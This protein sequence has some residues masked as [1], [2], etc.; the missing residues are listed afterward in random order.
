MKRLIPLA[1]IAVTTAACNQPAEPP[2]QAAPVGSIAAAGQTR[3]AQAPAAAL[4][5]RAKVGQP[6]PD[7]TLP[8]LDGK[9]VELSAFKG[10]TVVL[11]WFNAG[12]PFVQLSHKKGG[13]KDVPAQQL[14]KGVVWLAI[15]SSAPGKQ[16]HG[17]E[18]NEK[19]K[20]EFGMSYPILLD[21]K[22][23][24]GRTYGA[25]RTPHMVIVDPGGT[26][27]YAGA[28]DSTRGGEPEPGEQVTNHVEVALGELAAGKPI[29]KPE[30]ES[31][32]CSVKY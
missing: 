5:A 19:G 6:A 14:G 8:D 27:V 7:F 2:P 1:F 26:L 21:E 25:Q 10:K 23:E 29:S 32:G 4:A 11:E 16:G 13:L 12:C 30:T 17:K 20:A 22:G 9:Q 15:N 24:V 3:A 31:F 18:A 28:I